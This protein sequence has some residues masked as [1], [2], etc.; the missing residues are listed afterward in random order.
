MRYFL[1]YRIILVNQCSWTT[2]IEESGFGHNIINT[3]AH[4]FCVFSSWCGSAA[5]HDFRPMDEEEE[6][7]GES[8]VG[9][10]R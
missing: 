6:T 7:V 2:S 4:S 5:A 1:H 10:N 9:G 8:Q 3:S